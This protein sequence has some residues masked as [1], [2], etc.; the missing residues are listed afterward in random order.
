MAPAPSAN[1]QRGRF[2]VCL[3]LGA[4]AAPWLPVY[5]WQSMMRAQVIGHAGDVVSYRWSVGNFPRLL[6]A[7]RYTRP[8]DRP[9][10]TL[11]L[12]LALLCVVAVALAWLAWRVLG[13]VGQR[14]D[15]NPSR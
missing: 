13:R 3:L 15:R 8:E 10:L 6:D 7:L 11:A 5:P 14:A 9:E 1:P 4:L 2:V 12:D